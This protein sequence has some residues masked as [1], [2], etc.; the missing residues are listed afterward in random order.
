[1]SSPFVLKRLHPVGAPLHIAPA[2]VVVPIIAG[3]FSAEQVTRLTVLERI[4]P[5]PTDPVAVSLWFERYA[6]LATATWHPSLA[7]VVAI[8]ACVALMYVLSI[9]AHELGHVAA[10][11]AYGLRVDTIELGLTGGFVTLPDSDRLT[12]GSLG[13]IAGAGPAVTA[14]IA[15]TTWVALLAGVAGGRRA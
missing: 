14:A 15:G 11:R 2:V 10:A 3:W 7:W 8:G 6:S 1:M 13:A 4:P 5:V 12:A 9:L